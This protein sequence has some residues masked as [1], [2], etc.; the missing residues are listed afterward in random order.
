MINKLLINEYNIDYIMELISRNK[1]K[2]IF[3]QTMDLSFFILVII[4]VRKIF[5]V[6]FILFCI[7]CENL[8]EVV[9]KGNDDD[10]IPLFRINFL[11]NSSNIYQKT[12]IYDV[13]SNYCCIISFYMR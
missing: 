7:T 4:I 6:L 9:E 5:V 1:K 8:S 2:K 12:T 13:K 3:F 10:K 11:F